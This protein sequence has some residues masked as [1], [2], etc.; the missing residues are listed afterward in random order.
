MRCLAISAEYTAA[1]VRSGNCVDPDAER[2]LTG[3][4]L[5]GYV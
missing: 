1:A 4:A 2:F 5:L 3:G